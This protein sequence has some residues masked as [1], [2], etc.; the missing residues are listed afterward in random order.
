MPLRNNS[1]F[2]SSQNRLQIVPHSSVAIVRTGSGKSG[3]VVVINDRHFLLHLFSRRATAERTVLR[4]PGVKP[5]LPL[6]G[7]VLRN[8]SRLV[9]LRVQRFVDFDPTMSPDGQILNLPKCV[10]SANGHLSRLSINMLNMR[11]KG[12]SLSGGLIC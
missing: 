8:L 7:R 6:L 1:R 2:S 4:A 12:F 10:L 11:K 3:S 5:F 9:K